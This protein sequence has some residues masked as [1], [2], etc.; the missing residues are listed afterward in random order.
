M[1]IQKCPIWDVDCEVTNPY[2][3]N[4]DIYLVR[5]SYR[6]GGDYEITAD[7]VSEIDDGT[8]GEAE[9]ARVTSILVEQWIKGVHV[10]RLTANDV[11]RARESQRLPAHERAERLLRL[12]AMCSPDVGEYLDIGNR[13]EGEERYLRY[14]QE[15]LGWSESI[16][17][18]KL[19]FLSKYLEDQGWI[20]TRSV[21]GCYV[22]TVTVPGYRRIEELETNP[23]SSQCFV[24]MWFGDEMDKAYENGIRPAIEATGYSPVRIDQKQFNGKI[25]D[26]IIAQIRRSRFLVADFTQG[27]DGARGGV[28]YEAGFAHGLNLQVIFT[29]RKDM[30]DKAHFDTRQF[31]H[32]VWEDYDDLRVKLSNRIGSVLGDG[33][34][35]KR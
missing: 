6:A 24:A 16:D 35:A 18:P 31:N 29:C 25:D 4:P 1:A 27:K 10:P 33:P 13:D 32:I 9:K 22:A 11:R 7:A 20:K 17:Y 5:G 26:E 28:Y 2:D 15:A 12:L 23:D 34:N 19:H 14:Y 21:H 8:S 3:N 30:I